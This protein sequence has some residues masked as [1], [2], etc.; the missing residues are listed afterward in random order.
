MRR[1]SE[2]REGCE[3]GERRMCEWCEK[4]VRTVEDGREIGVRRV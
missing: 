4:D 2:D 3:N 1:M